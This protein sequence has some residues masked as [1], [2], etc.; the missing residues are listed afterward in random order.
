MNQRIYESRYI[1]DL[2]LERVKD[3]K[4]SK[5]YEEPQAFI[6]WFINIY[7]NS[8][9]DIFISDG[10]R[11]GKVD[12]FFTTNDGRTVRHHIINSKYTEEYGKTAPVKFYE[13]VSYFLNAFEN[14]HRRD[15]YLS[16]AVKAELQPYY[17][18]IFDRFDDGQ[19]ELMFITNLKRNE[20]HAIQVADKSIRLFHLDELIQYI[21][22]DIDGAMPRTEPLELTSIHQ[23][24]SADKSETEV[25]TSIVFARL[26][27]FIKY[28]SHD[29]HDLL[30]ARNVRLS[31]GNTSPNKAI[32]ETFR[33]CPKEFAFSNNGITILCERHF[34]DPETK[35]LQLI[36]P[37]VVNGSQT[38]HS[39]R[40]VHSPSQNARVMVRIIVIPPV[41][42]KDV[43]NTVK[44]KKEIINK[45]AIRTNQ[46]NPIK[47]TN[48]IANDDY[49][50]ELY[51]YF[52]RKNL[53][54]ERR[55]KEWIYRSRYLKSVGIDQGPSLTWMLQL[56]A[57]YHWNKSGLGP[58]VAKSPNE[59]C[60][61]T[62]YDQIRENDTELVYQI[63][64]LSKIIGD[65][66]RHLKAVKYIGK[67][68]N[69]AFLT[70]FSLIVGGL[71]A[72][73]LR[74]GK[75]E[76]SDLLK[77]HLQNIGNHNKWE[78]AVRI[79]YQVVDV[80]FEKTAQSHRLKT[81][82]VLS[83]SNYFKNQSYIDKILIKSNISKISKIIKKDING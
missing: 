56:I 36:N 13:E 58:V 2:I 23:V 77:Q 26:Y 59:L 74:F 39:I 10:S 29:Q 57:S 22:D 43:A 27:D 12:A 78:K 72:V 68:K 81:S 70:V 31:L 61:S 46:Q 7:F 30:F 44:T 50:M 62:K 8:P 63:Y 66:N 42:S 19:A 3:V 25:A 21:I 64:L 79:A 47:A 65:C 33:K 80:Y 75:Q 53:F 4:Q 40:D 34:H 55:Q 16:R 82:E 45:I 52:R 15:E 67:Y 37:R 9:Q 24:L 41:T 14:R 83:P 18:R 11:D 1:F 35:I 60:E 17:K 76:T 20:A 38:L 48:L 51:R 69:Y 71:Q 28:M 49:Q 6:Y 73:K 54:Y 5:G 32:K